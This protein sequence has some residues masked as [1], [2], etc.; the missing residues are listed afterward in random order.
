VLANDKNLSAG[1]G[2]G[3]GEPERKIIN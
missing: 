3:G 2:S 1:A